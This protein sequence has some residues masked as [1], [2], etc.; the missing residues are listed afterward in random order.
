VYFEDTEVNTLEKDKFLLLS[1]FEAISIQGTK[2]GK[3]QALY[4]SLTK[5]MKKQKR[6]E[7][8]DG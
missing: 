3:D 1:M 4:T 2:E 6:E 8:G 7:H 5:H